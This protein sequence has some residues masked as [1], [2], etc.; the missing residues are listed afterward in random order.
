MTTL[1]RDRYQEFLEKLRLAR[2][3]AR[4]TQVQASMALKKHQAFISRCET[5]ERRVDLVEVQILAELYG[6]PL[7]FFLTKAKGRR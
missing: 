7:S 4:M 1:D 3:D 6:K 2:L 5:G